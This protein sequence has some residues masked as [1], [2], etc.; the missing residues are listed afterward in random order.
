M[1][2]PETAP[3]DGVSLH[4]EHHRRRR[5]VRREGAPIPW[6]WLALAGLLLILCSALATRWLEENVQRAGRAALNEEERAWAEVRADGQTLVVRGTAPSSEAAGAALATLES[7]RGPTWLGRLRAPRRVE[8]RVQIATLDKAAP[9]PEVADVPKPAATASTAFFL[10]R[11][12]AILTLRGLARSEADRD[13][14]V[15]RARSFLGTGEPPLVRVDDRLLVSDPAPHATVWQSGLD[16]LRWCREGRLRGTGGGGVDV[17]CVVRS[18]DRTELERTLTGPGWGAWVVQSKL[19]DAG[20]VDACEASL[21]R[22]LEE[23]VIEFDTNSARLR[24]SAIELLDAVAARAARC[25][26]ALRIEGHTDHRGDAASNLRLSQARAESVAKALQ[27]RGIER[28]RLR[29]E[30]FGESR[31]REPGNSP[32]ALQQN[33]RIE[34]HVIGS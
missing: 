33:R 22:L 4:V 34:I 14:V 8:S 5:V 7:S 25:P 32:A 20:E 19:L 26:G 16:V 17:L 23:T 12:D 27:A 3:D 31:P 2:D 9:C 10:Q 30:G 6:G 29:T 13:Q 28:A 15:A 21:T 1:P 11:R 18:A 24:S